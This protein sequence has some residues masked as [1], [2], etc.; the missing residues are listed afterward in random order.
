MMLLGFQQY[1]ISISNSF[2]MSSNYS[3]KM[4]T[5]CYWDFHTI[6]L[7]CPSSVILDSN[8]ILLGLPDD[9]N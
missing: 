8:I 2:V 7:E 5:R 4:S 9:F 3:V 1:P 6:L